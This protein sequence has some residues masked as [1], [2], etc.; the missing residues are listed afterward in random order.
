MRVAFFGGSFNPPHVAHVLACTYVIST[1]L[2]E[3]VLVVPVYQHP[4]DK[5][6]APFEDR[7]TMA[8]LAV[9]WIPGVEVS[10]V[11]R[12]LEAPSLTLNTLQHLSRE[13]PSWSMRLMVGSDVLFEAQK[14]HA[15]DK[16]CAIAPPLVLGRVGF[17][18]ADAP[19]SVLPELSSTRVRELLADPSPS[20]RALLKAMLPHAV[21]E[22]AE[23]RGLYA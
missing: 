10:A 16:I 13:H 12:E 14:W 21:L 15:F 3:Q 18:H 19:V 1:G 11:E 22:H 23:A 8:Q 20:S 9:G 2:A 17:A 6:L 4:F 5:P 7:L